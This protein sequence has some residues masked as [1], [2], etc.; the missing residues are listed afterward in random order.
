M[1]LFGNRRGIAIQDKQTITKSIGKS[2][3]QRRGMLFYREKGGSW[4][5]L[6]WMKIHCWKVRVQ[7]GDDFSLAELLGKEEIFLLLR[8]VKLM[9]L[10]V[11]VCN[12]CGVVVCEGSPFWTSDFILNEF[13]FIVFHIF[14]FS[15]RSFFKSIVDQQSGVWMFLGGEWSFLSPCS[16]SSEGGSSLSALCCMAARLSLTLNL[17]CVW[18]SF[19]GVC[20]FIV[21]QRG[22]ITG[23]VHSTM[24]LMSLHDYS[25]F[26]Q[27]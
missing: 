26:Y 8:V 10:P 11:G 15:S 13:S 17:S 24:M 20:F 2:S 12:W 22:K 21:C 6:F 23:K 18:M 5:G 16:T 3:K 14:P 9:I 27:R 25:H 7:G 4:E 1:G 19:V